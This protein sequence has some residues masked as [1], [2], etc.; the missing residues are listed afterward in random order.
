[1]RTLRHAGGAPNRGV[2]VQ[3]IELGKAIPIDL[4][5]TDSNGEAR[6]RWHP[7]KTTLLLTN[8]GVP[9]GP[10]YW[11]GGL[12]FSLSADGAK[13]LQLSD[14]DGGGVLTVVLPSLRLSW[15]DD[16]DSCTGD[17][18]FSNQTLFKRNAFPVPVGLEVV[19]SSYTANS[20][21]FSPGP[22]A[23]DLVPDTEL[24]YDRMSGVLVPEALGHIGEVVGD[25]ERDVS[26]IH[27]R[28][29][30]DLDGRPI[31]VI[32]AKEY[33]AVQTLPVSIVE[34]DPTQ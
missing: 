12:N 31:E 18:V 33:A 16:V 11:K 17:L 28:I 13:A 1:V 34:F 24:D 21:I 32:C 20:V 8:R 2:T 30:T 29:D 22:L 5:V 15:P 6:L 3:T 25:L 19:T 27:N 4:G 7:G 26:S 9:V 23:R 14:V 10:M